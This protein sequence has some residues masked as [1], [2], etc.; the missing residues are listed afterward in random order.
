MHVTT[1]A[2]LLLAGAYGSGGPET[3][4]DGK[5]ERPRAG[6]FDRE[7][8]LSQGTIGDEALVVLNVNK[9]LD[10]GEDFA[11]PEAIRSAAGYSSDTIATGENSHVGGTGFVDQNWN[12]GFNAR[13]QGAT[14]MNAQ[15]GTASGTYNVSTPNP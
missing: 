12:S 3:P 6:I 15:F 8:P 10:I 9:G 1:L 7:Q 14:S 2:A 5:R 4:D 11:S 13:S